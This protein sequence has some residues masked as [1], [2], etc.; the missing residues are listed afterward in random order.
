MLTA[1]LRSPSPSSP[2]QDAV[3]DEQ[4]DRRC[5][6]GR[7]AAHEAKA[8]VCEQRRPANDQRGGGEADKWERHEVGQDLLVEIRGQQHEQCRCA[9]AE[10]GE[11]AHVRPVHL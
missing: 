1:S 9:D 3:G 6:A 2:A 11:V 8:L 4:E 10:D 5:D 7:D